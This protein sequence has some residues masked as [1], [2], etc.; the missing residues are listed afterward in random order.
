MFDA[1]PLQPCAATTGSIAPQHLV[2]RIVVHLLLLHLLYLLSLF[3]EGLTF[4]RTVA[5]E[6][7]VHNKCSPTQYYDI[8]LT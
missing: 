6:K 2:L 4:A 3:P 5:L 7:S 8:S 1:V